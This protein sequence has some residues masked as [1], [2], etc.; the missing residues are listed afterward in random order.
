MPSKKTK[1]SKTT[2]PRNKRSAARKATTRR[3]V[4][5]KTA[6]RKV[7][8]RK[9]AARKAT[10][11]TA[12]KRTVR[13]TAVRKAGARKTVA[14]KT[15]PPR[16]RKLKATPSKVAIRKPES[17]PVESVA[18]PIRETEDQQAITRVEPQGQVVAE[19]G[20]NMTGA[21]ISG[22]ASPATTESVGGPGPVPQDGVAEQNEPPT[23]GEKE[24]GNAAEGATATP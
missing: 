8:R 11:R 18:T 24:A 22:Q 5:R 1:S 9:T 16:S 21:A 2:P 4:V 15:T 10:V 7:A 17:K 12:K 13:K 6:A 14:R 19:V 3:A 20:V 23:P